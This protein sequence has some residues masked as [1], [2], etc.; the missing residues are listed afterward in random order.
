MSRETGSVGASYAPRRRMNVGRGCGSSF[1]TMI[2][3]TGSTRA[4]RR[5]RSSVRAASR[6]RYSASKLAR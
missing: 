4:L 1:I 2:S 6:A 5:L 3:A